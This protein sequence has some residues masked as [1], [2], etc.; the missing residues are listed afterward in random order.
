[1]TAEHMTV[2]QFVG[3]EIR[4]AREAKGVSR[5][6]LAK[7]FPVSESLVRWWESGRTVPAEDYVKRLIEILALP[8]MIQRVPDELVSKEVAP[9]WLGKWL[10]VEANSTT[11]LNFEPQVIPGLMQMEDY[12]R[13]VLR[14][15]KEAP[16]DLDE[17]VRARL[18]R[19]RVLAKEGPPLYH[20]IIDEA[21]LRRPVGGNKGEVAYVD[22]AL[23]GDV[24]EKPDDVAAIRRIWQRLSAKALLEDE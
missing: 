13:A 15:G 16:L 10:T 1:M 21:V 14:L 4:R 18:D 7:M 3:K 12:A 2:R 20:A 9:E 24:V 5:L 17:Q 23:R 19:Q 22:N 8:E 11:L 6:E